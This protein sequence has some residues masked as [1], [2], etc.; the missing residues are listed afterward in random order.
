MPTLVHTFRAVTAKAGLA[1]IPLATPTK[2]PR[3]NQAT[4][5]VSAI[6]SA[7]STTENEDGVAGDTS[8]GLLNWPG[9]AGPVD[10]S[11][12]T[13]YRKGRRCRWL[14]PGLFLFAR[15]SQLHA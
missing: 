2:P 5:S 4:Q 3:G 10:M 1:V 14:D 11:Q 15:I 12:P 7:A 6:K 9:S 13:S 8:T